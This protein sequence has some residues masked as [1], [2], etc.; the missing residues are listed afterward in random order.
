MSAERLAYRLAQHAETCAVDDPDFIGLGEQRAVKKLIE[1]VEGLFGAKPD[2]V[3]L[4]GARGVV[5]E[6][7][8]GGLCNRGQNLDDVARRNLEPECARFDLESAIE[9]LA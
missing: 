1:L 6:H 9:E 4:E 5:I 3:D 7:R 2:E 8:L